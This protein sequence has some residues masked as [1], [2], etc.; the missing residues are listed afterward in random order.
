MIPDA[1]DP[2]AECSKTTNILFTIVSTVL[3]LWFL[4]MG[5]FLG[6]GPVRRAE[7]DFLGRY[8]VDRSGLRRDRS[9]IG[10]RHSC[11][12]LSRTRVK[13]FLGSL[14]NWV[15]PIAYSV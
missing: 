14:G 8:C 2:R 6:V 7:S 12:T 15:I 1:V 10:A 11:S 5:V 9:N 3:I 13:L 4:V